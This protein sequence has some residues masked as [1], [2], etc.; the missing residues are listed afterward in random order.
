MV[1]DI[2]TDSVYLRNG[3]GLW[4]LV[5]F[6]CRFYTA[7]PSSISFTLAL[8]II[9]ICIMVAITDTG[10]LLSYGLYKHVVRDSPFFEGLTALSLVQ[11]K[12]CIG[13][14]LSSGDA[15]K[16]ISP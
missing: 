15:K 11:H 5:D 10:T 8:I 9:I 7:F 16:N 3:F 2:Y 1:S 12:M 13:V 14:A 4:F 6:G